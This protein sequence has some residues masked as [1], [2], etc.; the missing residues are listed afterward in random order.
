MVRPSMVRTERDL[1]LIAAGEGLA[2]EP[3]FHTS[4][5]SATLCII[6]DK[7]ARDVIDCHCRDVVVSECHDLS[8]LLRL[9]F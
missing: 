4:R 6:V 3:D 7:F 5:M 8:L 1:D 2:M 9:I